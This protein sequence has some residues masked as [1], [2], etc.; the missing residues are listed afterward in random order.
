MRVKTVAFDPHI[1]FRGATC[2]GLREETNEVRMT[3]G[4]AGTFISIMD[5]KHVADV[6]HVPLHRVRQ[7]WTEVGQ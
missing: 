4:A 2:S 7:W 3:L 1:Q 5:L 6:T